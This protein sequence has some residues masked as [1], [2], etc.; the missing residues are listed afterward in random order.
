MC[1]GTGDM[2]PAAASFKPLTEFGPPLLTLA[3]PMPYPFLQSIFDGLLPHG[4][5]HYWKADFM[6]ELTDEA[7]AEHIKFGPSIPTVNSAVHIY[8]LDGAVHDVKTEETAFAYRDINFVHII[9]AVTPDPLPLPRY[10]EWVKN[11]WAALHPL[12][13]GG[14]YVNFLMDEGEDRIASSYLENHARLAAIKAKYDPDNLFQMNQNI[15][16]AK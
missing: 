12:S 10:R 16:P 5:H 14:A 8:P 15:K 9:A 11:Y 6:H 4:L 13:A 7:I 2:E 1:S 3:H